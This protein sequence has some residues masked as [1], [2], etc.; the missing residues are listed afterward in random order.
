ME[1]KVNIEPVK[2]RLNK[3]CRKY[4][5]RV[6]TLPENHPVRQRTS[7][8]YSPEEISEQKILIKLN[9]LD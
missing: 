1:L 9:Y 8:S 6:I 2:V 4:A 7:Y 3:K 5:L